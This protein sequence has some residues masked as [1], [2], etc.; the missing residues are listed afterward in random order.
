MVSRNGSTNPK[1][2][3]QDLQLE[4]M[5]AL[6]EWLNLWRHFFIKGCV[7]EVLQALKTVLF[8]IDEKDN[9]IL[10][11]LRILDQIHSDEVDMKWSDRIQ[12]DFTRVIY[13]PEKLTVFPYESIA[14][15]GEKQLMQPQTYDI[16]KIYLQ[17]GLAVEKFDSLPDD[18]IAVE[19]EFAYILLE[20][21]LKKYQLGDDEGWIQEFEK[22]KAFLEDHILNW[23]PNFCREVANQCREPF[24][25]ATF[26]LVE[27]GLEE[28]SQILSEQS[29][30]LD[31]K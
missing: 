5:V 22:F 17:A 10:A 26:R 19:L 28:V 8:L 12:A 2:H 30:N 6:S 9:D 3:I 27:I 13:G 4:E 1:I 21:I 18:F 24:V 29:S 31:N 11:P 14:V 20:R 23:I 15:S 7:P 25:A 16:R